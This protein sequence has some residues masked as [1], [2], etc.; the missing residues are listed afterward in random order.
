MENKINI[1]E[2]LKDCPKGMELD[3]ALFDNVILSR[4]DLD[5]NCEY[6][7]RI[8]T[9]NGCLMD[10]TK[11]GTYTNEEEAKCVIFPKGK[12]TWEGFQKPWT[13]QDAKDGDIVSYCD[14]W[15][16]IFKCIHGIW[17]SSYCFITCDGEFHTG[18]ERHEVGTTVN[19]N[20]QRATK[21]QRNLLFQKM[22]EA[23]HKWNP[24]TK[25]LMKL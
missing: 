9:K 8:E 17:Y 16:C 18:Y 11:Y 24:Q 14:G 22:K 12:T 20:A 4:I 19:G 3:C 21:E 23:G 1:V 7:I 6:P 2:L 10:L 5:S 13:I 15:T 25:T